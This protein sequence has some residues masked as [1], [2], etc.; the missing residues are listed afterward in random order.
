M[1]NL[2]ESYSSLPRFMLKDAIVTD[3]N[4]KMPYGTWSKEAYNAQMNKRL[5]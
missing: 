4:L 3:V 2:S 5:S 1:L